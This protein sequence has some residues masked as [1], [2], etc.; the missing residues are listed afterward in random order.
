A[1]GGVNQIVLVAL[2]TGADVA[3]IT[4]YHIFRIFFILFIIA[5]GIN[6]F[7]KYRSN[8]RED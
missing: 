2:A 3:M 7:L 4:S 1:P 5:P 8:K 6:Y